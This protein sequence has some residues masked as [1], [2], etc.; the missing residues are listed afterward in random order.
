MIA[1][2]VPRLFFFF[3]A[4]FQVGAVSLRKQ[5]A[6][7]QRGSAQL[8]PAFGS[9]IQGPV[10]PYGG[11]AQGGIRNPKL[12]RLQ[13]HHEQDSVSSNSTPGRPP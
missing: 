5:S 10:R 3:V 12:E 2:P 7:H 4:V 11:A 1:F 9:P 8:G 13:G 6:L